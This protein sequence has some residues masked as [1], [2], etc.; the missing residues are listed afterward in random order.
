MYVQCAEHAELHSADVTYCLCFSIIML[1]TDLH[2]Q[3]MKD[4]ARMTLEDYVR[5]NT[6]YGEMNRDSPLPASLLTSIYRSILAEQLLI[7]DDVL[8]SL[9]F[10]RFIAAERKHHHA[11]PMD[12]LRLSQPR[13]LPS[14]RPLPRPLRPRSPSVPFI[15]PSFHAS[16]HAELLKAVS[17]LLLQTLQTLLQHATTASWVSTALRLA[18]SLVRAAAHAQNNLLVDSL[19]QLLVDRTRLP[20]RP[21]RFRASLITAENAR[22]VG[23][24]GFARA[25]SAESAETRVAAGKYALWL[26]YSPL[27][28]IREFGRGTSEEGEEGAVCVGVECYKTL[29]E[30]IRENGGSIQKG[31]SDVVG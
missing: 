16:M 6:T 17:P 25:E 30:I 1:N 23:D 8:F 11:A 13:L 12:R 24:L 20:I 3:N 2:N 27:R 18:R 26:E 19:V 29:L 31:Y 14:Q 9:K 10:D 4:E 21:L 15:L 7:V 22:P 5:F 28:N